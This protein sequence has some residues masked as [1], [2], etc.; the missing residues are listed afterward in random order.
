MGKE[1]TI[2]AVT[3]H[4]MFTLSKLLGFV[5]EPLSWVALLLA[6]G[7]LT[8]SRRPR[9]SRS[10]QGLALAGLLVQG[11]LGPPTA[12][13][14]YL[15]SRYRVHDGL[16]DN[17]HYV[18]VLVLGGA[19]EPPKLWAA[20]GL[21]ALNGAAERMTA[22]LPLL[23]R[24]PHLQL[25]YTGGY[26]RLLGDGRHEAQQVMAFYRSMGIAPQRLLLESAS[27]NT[28]ENA[29]FSAAMPGIDKSQPW[30]L[31]TSAWHMPRAM[32]TF[33]KAGWN[34][35]AYPVDFLTGA[36]ADWTDYRWSHSLWDTALHEYL[37]LL[38]YRLS[39]KL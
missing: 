4:A 36:G 37:G 15:E 19:M 10:L 31:V 27:R 9:L 23:Q 5:T 25:L 39:G 38:A 16:E 13:L 26:G 20:H 7:L 6:A 33:E 30:L 17:K 34:V 8:W 32:A 2:I 11:W 29:V 35:T 12:L 1:L 24:Q 14:H 22:P 18:G 3:I 21:P 28:Y